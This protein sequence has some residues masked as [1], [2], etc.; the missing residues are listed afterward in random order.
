MANPHFHLENRCRSWRLTNAQRR[1]YKRR[2]FGHYSPSI[3]LIIKVIKLK[4]SSNYIASF[5][6]WNPWRSK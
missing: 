4:K 2:A 6:S 1:L 5:L 3:G